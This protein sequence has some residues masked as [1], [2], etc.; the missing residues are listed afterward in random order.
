MLL[1]NASDGRRKLALKTAG[2]FLVCIFFVGGYIVSDTTTEEDQDQLSELATW[3]NPFAFTDSEVPARLT[4]LADANAT[5]FNSSANGT[6]ATLVY[7]TRPP[8]AVPTHAPTPA[9]PPIKINILCIPLPGQNISTL[10]GEMIMKL[11]ENATHPLT[12]HG[13][14]MK[15]ADDTTAISGGGDNGTV[16]V[17]AP[18]GKQSTVQGEFHVVRKRPL[19]EGMVDK[20]LT[21]TAKGLPTKKGAKKPKKAK[22]CGWKCDDNIAMITD[23][24][25]K[26]YWCP[27]AAP[28]GVPTP[29]PT[30]VPTFTYAPTMYGAVKTPKGTHWAFSPA[31]YKFIGKENNA[32]SAQVLKPKVQEAELAGN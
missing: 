8:T 10:L 13:F 26:M 23:Q 24:G 28:T 6:N 9:P 4:S 20:E 16:T 22:G 12:F 5:A 31:L 18:K 2:V 17:T 25:Q 11:N 19:G 27:T 1:A 21:V 3:R 32:K 7:M 30:P 14:E 15:A 29:S